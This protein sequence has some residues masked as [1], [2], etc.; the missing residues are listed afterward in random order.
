M[1]VKRF[2]AAGPM[3]LNNWTQD[4][5]EALRGVI[6]NQDSKIRY[7]V[8]IQEIG[9]C[10]TPHLQI[11][12][13]AKSVLSVK[14]WHEQLGP[15]VANIVPTQNIPVAIE[16]C[17]G[18][19]NGQPKEGSDLTSVEEYGIAPNQGER[20]DLNDAAAAVRKRPL[21]ELLLEGSE[22]LPTIAKHYT[23]FKEY[24]QMCRLKENYELAKEEHNEY[25]AT[26]P[27]MK[28]EQDVL[29]IVNGP[30]DKRA[31]HWFYEE[32]GDVGKTVMAKHLDYNYNAF[33]CT[34]GKAVDIA[35]A[36]KFEP[37][38][39]FNLVASVDETTMSYLYKVL[40]EFKDG[41]FSSGKYNSI[42]K[43]FKIPTV[44][45]FSNMRPDDSKMK[46]NRLKVHRIATI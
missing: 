12:A 6:L 28:W 42:V 19:R 31:I 7:I 35:H 39:V 4:E 22:H 45:V 36:Y 18:F 34:G 11:F 5:I 43:R 2:R 26:K 17:K 10:G 38:V 30:V 24:D 20:T 32:N 9:V 8:W 1:V 40:E 33:Y 41:I 13:Y 23:F 3:T 25:W 15:R 29:D 46:K 16:Y 27:I 37:I 44:L 21:E 14:G